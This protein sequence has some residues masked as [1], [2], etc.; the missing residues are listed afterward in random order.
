MN[1]DGAEGEHGGLGGTGANMVMVILA[2]CQ[3]SHDGGAVGDRAA[4][5][6][7]H[8]ASRLFCSWCGIDTR[9]DSSS[10]SCFI[11]YSIMS[12]GM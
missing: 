12:P 2:S 3:G 7:G 1:N 6:N 11:I 5:G 8:S 9:I 10:G 4:V